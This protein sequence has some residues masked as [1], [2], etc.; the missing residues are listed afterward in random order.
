MAHQT[1]IDPTE[2]RR[3]GGVFGETAR[4]IDVACTGLGECDL[5]AHLG[6]RYA[7]HEL[8]YS[9]GLLAIAQSVRRLAHTAR[10]FGDGL[11]NAADTLDGQDRANGQSI[12]ET[13]ADRG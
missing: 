2:I 12:A 1:W 4:S 9:A 3:I 13:R 7:H 6:I 8:A 10:H 5:G 11:V